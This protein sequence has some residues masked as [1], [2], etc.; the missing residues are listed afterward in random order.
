VLNKMDIIRIYFSN[1]TVLT[2]F[3]FSST[4]VLCL[5]GEKL[6]EKDRK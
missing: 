2:T 5:V 1:A 4:L 6:K 3:K